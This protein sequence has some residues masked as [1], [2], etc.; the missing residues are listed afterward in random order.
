MSRPN[1]PDH[2]SVANS[3]ETPGQRRSESR[4][5]RAHFMLRG[6]LR[7][8]NHASLASCNAQR[9]VLPSVIPLLH[10]S[11]AVPC[12]TATV[13]VCASV[14]L[15]CVVWQVGCGEA[16]FSGDCAHRTLRKRVCV[17]SCDDRVDAAG[18]AGGAGWVF[19][20]VE[21]DR[22]ADCRSLCPVTV[23]LEDFFRGD[24]GI[25]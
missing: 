1:R 24:L 22:V 5:E 8:T 20:E 21:R 9:T 2:P 13:A 18:C 12:R 10:L 16:A 15:L 25:V 19:G 23:A 14:G 6:E 17:D 4:L 11:S 7:E 3:K